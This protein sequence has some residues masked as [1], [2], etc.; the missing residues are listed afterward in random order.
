MLRS[1]G[2]GVKRKKQR[3]ALLF[4]KNRDAFTFLRERE[5]LCFF[6]FPERDA[7]A[8]LEPKNTL[9]RPVSLFME[10]RQGGE[11][12]SLERKK[13]GRNAFAFL[14]PKN[15]WEVFRPPNRFFAGERRGGEDF[16]LEGA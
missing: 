2:E 11:D 7:F 15:S 1:F 8:F 3:D 4:W 14:E 10:E 13:R 9:P 12:R 6:V 5:I 16:F